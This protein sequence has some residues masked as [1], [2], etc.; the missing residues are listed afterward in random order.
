LS[1]YSLLIGVPEEGILAG[2]DQDGAWLVAGVLVSLLLAGV[3]GWWG[4]AKQV[5]D[6][7]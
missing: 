3:V 7:F 1:N 6:A 5:P 2:P 4:L